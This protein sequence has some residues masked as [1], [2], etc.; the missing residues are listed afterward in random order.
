[1]TLRQTQLL[2]QCQG[3][4]IIQDLGLVQFVP[5]ILV[6]DRNMAKGEPSH[7]YIFARRR[8]CDVWDSVLQQVAAHLLSGT[9]ALRSVGKDVLAPSVGK[10]ELVSQNGSPNL[11]IVRHVLLV[12]PFFLERF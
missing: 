3:S 12:E 8:L 10:G 4:I 2:Q 9:K 11:E 6:I 7:Q 1:M 5:R